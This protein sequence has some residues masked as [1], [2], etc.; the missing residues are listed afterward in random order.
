MNAAMFRP[1]ATVAALLVALAGCAPIEAQLGTEGTPTVWAIGDSIMVGAE[2][3]LTE[4]VPA[5]QI[6]AESGRPFSTGIDVLARRLSAGETPDVLV[7]ALGTNAGASPA[8]ID[9]VMELAADVDEVI[10]VNVSVPRDWEG[11]TNEA[12]AAAIDSSANASLVDWHRESGGRGRLF[13]SDGFHPNSTGSE[14]WANLI[15]IEVKN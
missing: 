11:P 7:V 10:F 14:L 8:Q 13:R 3:H 4:L 9:Q 15:V 2:T 12:L 1:I 6:D 5:M